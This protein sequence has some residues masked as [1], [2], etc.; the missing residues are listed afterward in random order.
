L[1]DDVTTNAKFGDSQSDIK[2]DSLK[3][4]VDGKSAPNVKIEIYAINYHEYE[5]SLHTDWLSLG[6]HKVTLTVS[7]NAGNIARASWVVQVVSI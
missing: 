2:M 6:K 1:N 7:D 5:M 4:M 3:V